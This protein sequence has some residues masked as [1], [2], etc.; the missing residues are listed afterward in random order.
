MNLEKKE[1]VVSNIKQSFESSSA[2]FLA[3]YKGSKC[4]DLNQVRTKLRSVE[5]RFEVVKNTLIKRVLTENKD[6]GEELKNCL[7]GPT[8]VIWVKND[9]VGSAKIISEFAKSNE[10]FLLKGGVVDGTVVSAE[11]IKSLADMPSREEL[12]S[13]LLSLMNAV[14]IQVLRVVNAPGT[15]VVRLL[16]AWKGEL[17][18]TGN[19]DKTDN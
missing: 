4:E 9:P 14:S 19:K 6:Y 5:A 8:A 16:N 15:Q 10:S 18:K 2:A 17:E 12:L 7:Q 1:A 11:D 3:D 13:K